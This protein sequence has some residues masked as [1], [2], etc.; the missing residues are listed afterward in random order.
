MAKTER[1]SLIVAS[2][3][4]GYI[5]EKGCIVSSDA[6][7]ALNEKIYKLLDEA[8]DRTKDNKR[9]TLRPYDF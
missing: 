6:M 1:E 5:K 4:K 7:G 3:V 8:T 2:K 9:S